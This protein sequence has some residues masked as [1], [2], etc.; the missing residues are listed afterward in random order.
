ME[1]V[2]AWREGSA[3][4]KEGAGDYMADYAGEDQI[5]VRTYRTI[6][7]VLPAYN[8]ESVIAE[9]VRVCLSAAEQYCPNVEVIVVDD[10]SRDRTGAILDEIAAQDSRVRVI[11]HMPNRGYGAALLSGF[12]AARGELLFFMDSDGQFDI[13]DIALLLREQEQAPDVVVLGYRQHRRDSALRRFNAWGW[14]RV[15]WLMLG[16]RGVRDI[17][18]AFKLFPTNLV[19]ACDVTAQG[20]MVNTELLVKLQ[21]MGAR[22]VQIPVHHY[23]RQHGTATGANLRVIARAFYELYRLR[24]RLQHWSAKDA[25]QHVHSDGMSVVGAHTSTARAKL[26]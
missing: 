24:F 21:Q 5:R 4:M 16:L 2:H 3:H 9:T 19:R 22:M 15:V 25:L 1:V 11:H 23:P 10:G 20:A 26:D 12:A 6:S 8:E 13:N 7:M 18:C 17:D 14:K